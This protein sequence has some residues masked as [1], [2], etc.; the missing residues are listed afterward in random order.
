[1]KKLLLILSLVIS[2][3]LYSQTST[4]FK[5]HYDSTNYELRV[6]GNIEDHHF[7]NKLSISVM[8]ADG[9]EIFKTFSYELQTYKSGGSKVNNNGKLVPFQGT[10]LT[11]L[12]KD[13]WVQKAPKGKYFIKY[14]LTLKSGSQKEFPGHFITL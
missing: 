3:N 12:V 10:H 1:M 6:Y 7:Y 5:T 4:H 11:I 8:D 2:F 14:K 9:K 13:Y